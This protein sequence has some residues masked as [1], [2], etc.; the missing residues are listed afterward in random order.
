MV[1]IDTQNQDAMRRGAS[2]SLLTAT[3]DSGGCSAV[4]GPRFRP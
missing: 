1:E 4:W 3:T 2:T